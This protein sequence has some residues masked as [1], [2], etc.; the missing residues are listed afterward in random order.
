MVESNDTSTT[1][2]YGLGVWAGSQRN[3]GMM[4]KN[5]SSSFAFALNES[6]L[7]LAWQ[8]THVRYRFGPVLTCLWALL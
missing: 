1:T 2:S 4:L 5:E 6:K 3:V 8:D 7:A